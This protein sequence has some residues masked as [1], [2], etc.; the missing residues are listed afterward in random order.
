[1]TIYAYDP[2]GVG[3][4]YS[5][6]AGFLTYP[7]FA[8]PSHPL[9]LGAM[10]LL[11]ANVIQDLQQRVL[12][13]TLTAFPLNIGFLLPDISVPTANVAINFDYGVISK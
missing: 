4:V 2:A 13:R 7:Y 6:S 9:Y 11:T 12:S 1:M 8:A 10:A 5:E 3:I